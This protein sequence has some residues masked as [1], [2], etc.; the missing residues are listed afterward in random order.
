MENREHCLEKRQTDLYMNW[1]SHAPFQWKSGT[2]KNLVKRPILIYSNQDL[3]EKE[4]DHLRTIFIKTNDCSGKTLNNL[5]FVSPT[6][7]LVCF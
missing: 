3:L 7:L 4:L 5:K 6:F 1:N 2:L